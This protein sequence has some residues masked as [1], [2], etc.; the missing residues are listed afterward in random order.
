MIT[1]KTFAPDFAPVEIL[2]MQLFDRL[3]AIKGQTPD[4]D[5]GCLLV[6]HRNYHGQPLRSFTAL[7][8]PLTATTDPK[9]SR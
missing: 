2:R 6:H 9:E 8:L 3:K 7:P 4:R 1:M 5:H